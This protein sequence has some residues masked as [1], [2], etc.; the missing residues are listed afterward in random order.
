MRYFLAGYSL[1]GPQR[2][3]RLRRGVGVQALL[4]LVLCASQLLCLLL[5]HLLYLLYLLYLLQLFLQ[6]EL[7]SLLQCF[8]LPWLSSFSSWRASCAGALALLHLTPKSVQTTGTPWCHEIE[9]AGGIADLSTAQRVQSRFRS[10]RRSI[11]IEKPRQPRGIRSL[12]FLYRRLGPLLVVAKPHPV[13]LSTHAMRFEQ[14]LP[15]CP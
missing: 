10:F 15:L 5:L 7:H 2:A 4:A 12:F 13:A 8:L 14:Q 11:C 6:G 9:D 1:M 3:S